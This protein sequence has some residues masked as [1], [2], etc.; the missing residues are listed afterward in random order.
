M[1]FNLD[2]YIYPFFKKILLLDILSNCIIKIIKLLY[3]MPEAIT[4]RF[5]TYHSHYKKKLKITLTE[6]AHNLFF[7]WL[8]LKLLSLTGIS[9]NSIVK[10]TT[11]YPYYKKILE[12]TKCV[13]NFFFSG[14]LSCFYYY[15]VTCLT[16]L[17]NLLL[18]ITCTT[19]KNRR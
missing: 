4:N 1:Y 10:F 12:I 19:K 16:V 15:L 7:F 11:Y 2:F 14:H 18:I 8:L 5:T 17:A 6:F 9:S 3:Y 13:Y